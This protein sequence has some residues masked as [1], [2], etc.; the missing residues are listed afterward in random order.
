MKIWK[1]LLGLFFLLVVLDGALRKWVLPS[2]ATPLLLLKDVVLWGGFLVYAFSRDPFELPRPLRSTWI[3]VLLVAYISVVL[4]QA[5]NVRQP[6]LIV[7]VI[8]LKAHLAYLPL[9]VLLPALL[10]QITEREG[11][12]FLWKYSVYLY[13]PILI[14]CVYQFFQPKTAW[15][16]QY[17]REMTTVATVEEHPRVTGTFSYI[18]S[19]APYLRFN[20]Y[21]SASILLAGIQW[22]RRKI[23]ALGSL[24]LAGTFVVLPMTGSRGNVLLVAGGLVA[25]ILVVKLKRGARLRILGGLVII[26]VIAVQGLSG[27]ILLEGWEALSTR[28]DPAGVEDAQG[29]T[30]SLLLA[31]FKR[32]EEAGLFGYGVGTQHQAAGRFVSGSIREAFIG[33]DNGALRLLA[34]LGILG[35]I[36]LLSLK[37]AL[38]YFA[39]QSVRRSQGPLELIIGAT[40]FCMLLSNLWLPI[41]F[42]LVSSALYWGSAGAMLGVWSLQEVRGGSQQARQGRSLV[43]S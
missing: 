38:M 32:I 35:W 17:V 40:A 20:G 10:S 33:T 28:V 19:L 30:L 2:Y 41:I 42:R 37:T 11:L 36:V 5:F 27:S 31:P 22:N 25:L 24:L 4:L 39:L 23:T 29:R 21:L 34:E 13:L 7:P 43:G 12:R 3:P 15:I 1:Q 16:N 14:L 9:I 6:N 8:G 26:S 18:G